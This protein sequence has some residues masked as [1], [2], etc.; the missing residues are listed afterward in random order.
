[1]PG[2]DKRLEAVEYEFCDTGFCPPVDPEPNPL[3]YFRPV[4]V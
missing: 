3:K 2:R 1:M 4:P